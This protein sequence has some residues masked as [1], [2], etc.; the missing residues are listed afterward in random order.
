MNR[1]NVPFCLSSEATTSRKTVG[2]GTSRRPQEL[3]RSSC[4]HI[5]RPK[6]TP[7]IG[8]PSQGFMGNYRGNQPQGADSSSLWPNRHSVSEEH[9]VTG[10]ITLAGS[11]HIDDLCMK[12]NVLRHV[13]P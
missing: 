5:T 4:H 13:Y 6:P 9:F 1:R 10:V 3:R 2:R 8:T 11:L 12:Y 7:V